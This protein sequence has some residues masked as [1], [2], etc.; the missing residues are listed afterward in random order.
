MGDVN[1]HYR[2]TALTERILQELVRGGRDLGSLQPGDLAGVDEFHLGGRAATDALL[3]SLDLGPGSRV[4]DV[5]CGIGGAARTIASSVGCSVSGVDLTEEFVETANDL[6][7]TVGLDDYTTFST[8]NALSLSFA[9]SEFDAVVMLHV[10]MN[11]ADKE[12]LFAELARVTKPGGYVAVYDI[13]LVGNR[14]LS[15]PVPW[16]SDASTS[17][18]ATPADYRAAMLA[19]GLEPGESVDRLELVRST[20]RA[21][22]EN[23]PV[24]NLSHLMGVDWPTMFGNLRAALDASLVAPTQIIGARPR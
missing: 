15:Y 22:A 2:Q 19:A 18:L 16:S 1:E 5:G 11:I 20:L 12:A 8:G 13:M 21:T 14:E 9:K 6:S 23:P 24:V 7:V 3:S 17:H 10:G 4:L